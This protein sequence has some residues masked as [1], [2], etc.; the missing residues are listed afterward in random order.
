MRTI[1]FSALLAMALLTACKTGKVCDAR[2]DSDICEL[3]HRSMHPEVYTNPHLTVPPTPEY[4]Q[5]RYRYFRHSKPTLYMLPDE[6]KKC[7]VNICDECVSEEQKWKA[8]H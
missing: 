3:H 8:T 2:G 7:K 6:C 1:F 4:V 5:A